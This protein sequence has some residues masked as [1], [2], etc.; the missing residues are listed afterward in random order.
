MRI[1]RAIINWCKASV[2]TL[3][4]MV[5]SCD[6]YEPPKYEGPEFVH[7]EEREVIVREEEGEVPIIVNIGGVRPLGPVTIQYTVA[8]NDAAVDLYTIKDEG[9]LTIPGGENSGA[10]QFTPEDNPFMDGEKIV[11]LTIISV[12][13]SNYTIGF[14]GP[15]RLNATTTI[16]IIDDDCPL[17][18]GFIVTDENGSVTETFDRIVEEGETDDPP[19]TEP[20]TIS[21]DPN[22]PKGII[23]YDFWAIEGATL[24]LRLDACP[25]EVTITDH[26]IVYVDQEQG[27]LRVTPEGSGVFDPESGI[28]TL[29]LELNVSLGTFGKYKFIYKK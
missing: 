24:K 23:I 25:R 15:D 14:P 1:D 8:P 17:D 7:F 5:A 28:L 27:P 29:E 16:K 9:T 12:S 10:I 6:T 20:V 22:D 4:M 11:E 18:R 2:L 21:I 26:D 13:N 19:I 3:V